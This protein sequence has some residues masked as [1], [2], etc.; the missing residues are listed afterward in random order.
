MKAE[1]TLTFQLQ[2]VK[3]L[4]ISQENQQNPKKTIDNPPREEVEYYRNAKTKSW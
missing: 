2:S 3:S 4:S 1:I